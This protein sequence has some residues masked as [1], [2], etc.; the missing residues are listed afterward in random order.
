MK[1]LVKHLNDYLEVR[2]Q[3]GF[4]LRGFER[5]LGKFVRFLRQEKTLFITTK[6]AVQWITQ[7]TG[8]ERFRADLL[9]MVRGFARYLSAVNPRNEVP[10]AELFAHR[11]WRKAPYLYSKQEV[12]RLVAAAGQLPTSDRL[13]PATHSILLGLLAATGMRIGEAIGLDREDVDLERDLL[14]LRRTKGGAWRLVPIH[15]T[16]GAKLRQYASFR[17][18]TCPKPKSP[19]FFLSGGGTR[20]TYRYGTRLVPSLVV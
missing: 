12:A 15:S 4:K 2:H 20:L 17:D 14:T 3:L 13:R 9:G 5:E 6:L 1:T 16:V 19:A 7:S 10:S 11:R 8:S 18:R